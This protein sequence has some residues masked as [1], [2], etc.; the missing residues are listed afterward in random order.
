M[1]TLSDYAHGPQRNRGD[2]QRRSCTCHVS[3]SRR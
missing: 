1:A 3:A 2:R